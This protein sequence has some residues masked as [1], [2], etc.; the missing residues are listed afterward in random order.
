M[1]KLFLIFVLLNPQLFILGFPY[2][3]MRKDRNKYLD[4]NF[5]AMSINDTPP[6]VLKKFVRCNQSRTGKRN[7]CQI[8]S[9]FNPNMMST[10]HTKAYNNQN[11]TTVQLKPQALH[12]CNE[13]GCNP[14][15]H[16]AAALTHTQVE[17]I[18]LLYN[19]GK[20]LTLKFKNYDTS[21][22]K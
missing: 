14:G 15:Q 10:Y 11:I 13:E 5:E 17:D 4:I 20:C 21:K 12:L 3:V 9:R 8:F 7:G 16:V 2:E 19:C 6:S 1:I 18:T 22:Q